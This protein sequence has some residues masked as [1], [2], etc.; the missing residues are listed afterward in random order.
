[1]E[2]CWFAARLAELC[3]A[4]GRAED[5]LRWVEEGLSLARTNDDRCYL[6]ELHRLKAETLAALGAGDA[7]IAAQYDAAIGISDEQKAAVLSLRTALSLARH[8]HAR[9][10]GDEA[11]RVLTAAC[12]AYPGDEDTPELVAGR[13]LIDRM[14]EG[15]VDA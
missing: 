7:E 1:M 11:W 13:A 9:G 12:S 10:R 2:T 8:L 14:A 4:G 5:A 3:L 6:S 15:R